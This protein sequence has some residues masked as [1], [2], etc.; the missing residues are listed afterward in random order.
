MF[1]THKKFKTKIKSWISIDKVHRFVR[2]FAKSYID[3]SRE[4]RKNAENDFKK[5]IFR[6]MNNTVFKTTRENLV[7]EPNY[8]TIKMIPYQQYK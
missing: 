6:L 2:S 7:S 8:Y 5:H 4:L 3:V 1:Y